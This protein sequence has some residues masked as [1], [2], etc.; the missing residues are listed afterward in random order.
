MLRALLL[1][2]ILF[3]IKINPSHSSLESKQEIRCLAENIYYESKSES[4]LGQRAV[5]LVTM[6][7]V[8]HD[9]YPDTVCGVVKQKCQFSWRCDGSKHKKKN[10][11]QYATA[12][13]VATHIFYNY[14]HV[15]DITYGALFFHAKRVSP[16]WKYKFKKTTTI[17]QHIFYKERTHVRT[18]RN[19]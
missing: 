4:N 17:G 8:Y 19:N 14:Q 2:S 13:I 10:E 3:F 9:K 1:I 6:N 15:K 12:L 5:A 18:N 7:R 11:L 16:A